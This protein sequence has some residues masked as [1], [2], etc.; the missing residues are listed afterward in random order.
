[1]YVQGF[2]I[3]VPEEKKEAYRELAE[4]FDNAMIERGALQIVEGWEDKV[5]DGKRT[6]FRRAVAIEPGEKVVFSWMIWPDKATAEAAH[7]AIHEDER[8]KAMTE[9]PFD[10]RRMIFGDFDPIVAVGKGFQ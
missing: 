4:W 2:V 3:P 8:F 6:D 7:E 1:M 5:E 9:F 10:G